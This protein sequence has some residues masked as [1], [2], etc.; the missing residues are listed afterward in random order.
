VQPFEGDIR[1]LEPPKCDA[2]ET[3]ELKLFLHGDTRVLV[4]AA[5]GHDARQ[6]QLLNKNKVIE[7]FQCHQFP[8]RLLQPLIKPRVL[9]L[10]PGLL[11]EFNFLILIPQSTSLPWAKWM[12][13]QVI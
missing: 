7:S 6:H 9:I 11:L 4:I 12:V 5:L 13:V 2:H 3:H 8:L 10:E 1:V